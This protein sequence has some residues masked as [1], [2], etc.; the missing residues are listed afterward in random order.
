MTFPKPG[1]QAWLD[2]VIEPIIDPRR[3]IIDPHHHFWHHERYPYLLEDLWKD[4]DSGHQ[5]EKTVYIECGSSYR[6]TGAKRFRSVGETE[7]AAKIA[8]ASREGRPG[9]AV[10]SGIVAHADMTLGDQLEGVLA[11][12]EEAGQGLFRGIRHQ[13]AV[14]PL[15]AEFNQFSNASEG[16]YHQ[17]AFHRGVKYLGERGHVFD[18]WHYFTQNTEFA[19]FARA[20]PDT[21]LV[22]DHFGTPLGIGKYAGKHAEIF[23]QLKRDISEIAKCPN[24]IA[25]LDVQRIWLG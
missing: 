22:L 24:V 21:T 2:Q 3:I 14:S 23:Q 15:P 5:V 11:A 1:S 12:H 19:A 7:F 9:Q 25:K 6:A 17:P 13:A 4:T 8:A 10:V 18:A 16:L 20:V